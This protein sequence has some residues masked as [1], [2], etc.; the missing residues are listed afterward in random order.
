MCQRNSNQDGYFNKFI[1][2]PRFHHLYHSTSSKSIINLSTLFPV[3][4]KLFGTYYGEGGEIPKKY[5][6]LE[7]EEM[8]PISTNNPTEQIQ[9]QQI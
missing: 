1:S 5:G 2:S 4:D 6:I 9:S 3:W 8:E 7:D